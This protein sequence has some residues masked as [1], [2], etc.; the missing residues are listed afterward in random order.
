MLNCLSNAEDIVCELYS[1]AN[2]GGSQ[3]S[4]PSRGSHKSGAEKISRPFQHPL[5][6]VD[7][8]SDGAN[9][10]NKLIPNGDIVTPVSLNNGHA[11]SFNVKDNGLHNSFQ[12]TMVDRQQSLHSSG[13]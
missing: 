10:S 12:S 2:T 11:E 1:A 8:I 7:S 9:Q 13:N 4:A 6:E 3:M 5:Q